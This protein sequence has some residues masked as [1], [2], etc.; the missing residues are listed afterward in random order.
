MEEVEQQIDA[1][2]KSDRDTEDSQRTA[3]RSNL[4]IAVRVF[5]PINDRS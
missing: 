3:L 4:S 1:R 2:V 5:N